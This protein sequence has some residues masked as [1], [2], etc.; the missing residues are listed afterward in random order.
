MGVLNGHNVIDRNEMNCFYTKESIDTNS[1][2]ILGVGLNVKYSTNRWITSICS[3]M[4]FLSLNAFIDYNITKG[5]WGEKITHF[6]PLIINEKH[7]AISHQCLI[8]RLHLICNPEDVENET[9]DEEKALLAITAIMNHFVVQLMASCNTT[10]CIQP[11]NKIDA[12]HA[13]EKALIGYCA[14]HHILCFLA[15]KYP[16]MKKLALLRVRR[17]INDETY[18]HKL[19]TPDLGKFLLNLAI[20][21]RFKW[22]DLKDAFIAECNVRNVRWYLQKHP[23][24][25]YYDTAKCS[26]S[27]RIECTLK[28]T[29]ISR[30]LVIFQIWFIRH[31]ARPNHCNSLKQILSSYNKTWGRPTKQQKHRLM[32][33]IKFILKPDDNYTFKRWIDYFDAVGIGHK[34]KTKHD[35]LLYLRNNVEKSRK[36]SY[37]KTNGKVLRENKFFEMKYKF[38]LKKEVYQRQYITKRE[39]NKILIYKNPSKF[40]GIKIE[41]TSNSKNKCNDNEL[42]RLLESQW[43]HIYDDQTYRWYIGYI[44]RYYQDTKT[45]DV[46]YVGWNKQFLERNIAL[47]SDRIAK[48]NTF[49]LSV[50]DRNFKQGFIENATSNKINQHQIIEEYEKKLD[51]EKKIKNERA[52]KIAFYHREFFKAITNNDIKKIKRFLRIKQDEQTVDAPNDINPIK[53]KKR[54]Q[55]QRKKKTKN[56]VA[57]HVDYDKMVPK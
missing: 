19:H 15:E 18:R 21:Y 1:K 37:H 47:N 13:S 42:M 54:K 57:V 16:K 8:K 12:K 10:D 43:V 30:R 56:G 44:I 23:V 45:C 48:I 28:A 26:D 20:C 4:D 5:I 36:K 33:Q 11:N 39:R 2:C 24:L 35:V 3:E 31:I 34:F 29:T 51:L 46:L 38:N 7:A 40:E 53:A 50:N 41:Y 14:F 32:K 6:L 17:F 49:P 22:E 55:R 27:E 9:F 25:E 52:E